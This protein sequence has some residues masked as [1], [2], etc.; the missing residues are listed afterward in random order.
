M[1]HIQAVI[2]RHNSNSFMIKGWAIAICTAVLAFAGTLKEPVL[3]LI[4]LLPVVVFWALDSL[5]L[6]NERCFISLYNAA[7]NGYSLKVKNKNLLKKHR[8]QTDLGEGKFEI[9]IVNLFKRDRPLIY[10]MGE[11]KYIIDLS[12]TIGK[13]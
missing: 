13:S 3:A 4:A 7:I 2:T 11:G 5:Y 9:D 8:V 12:S 6:A 1:D 10:K